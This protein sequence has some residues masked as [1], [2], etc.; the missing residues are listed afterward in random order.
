MSEPVVI[1]VGGALLENTAALSSFIQA[2]EQIAAAR[3]VVIVHGG[4][5]GV[6]A[7]LAKL[8]FQSEKHQGLRVTP[9]EQMPYIAG[10]LAGTANRQLCAIAKQQGLRPVG[11]SLFDGNSIECVAISAALHAVGKATPNDPELLLGLLEKGYVPI[12]SSIGCNTE[13][14]LLNVNADQAATAVAELLNADLYLLSDVT[15][16]LDDNN[17][18]LTQ[19]SA[20]QIQVLVANQTIKDGMLV[21]VN[22]ALQ[23]ANHLGKPVTIGSWADT[24]SLIANAT[25]QNHTP[26]GTQI[27][28]HTLG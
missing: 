23:A 17:K 16:V 2:I 4:G 15:A 25:Q 1:K 18:P 21:K 7:L 27:I 19:L 20:T 5:N 9:D 14:R 13:G 24:G 11:L 12:V 6:E 10:A 26:F 8:G 3:A 22:A 28:P